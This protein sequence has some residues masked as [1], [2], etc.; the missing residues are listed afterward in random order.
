[1]PCEREKE[2]RAVESQLPVGLSI[3]LS[4]SEGRC[5]DF[6]AAYGQTFNAGT[7]RGSSA[8]LQSPSASPP[9]QLPGQDLRQHTHKG[10]VGARLLGL[11]S[12][13]VAALYRNSGLTLCQCPL[14]LSG[15]CWLILSIRVSRESRVTVF[16][17]TPV[18]V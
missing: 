1:M 12:N 3:S 11:S 9:T 13:P 16:H 2:G 14:Y 7:K 17:N 4:D 10:S 8:P 6:S 15:L 18:T 5:A